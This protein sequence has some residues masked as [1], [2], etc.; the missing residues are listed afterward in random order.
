MS[1]PPRIVKQ[2]FALVV[3]N[4]RNTFAQANKKVLKYF[5]L[6]QSQS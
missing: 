4:L 5:H 6:Y 3:L 1:D 2:K